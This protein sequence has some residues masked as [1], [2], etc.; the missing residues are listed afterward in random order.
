MCGV[1]ND[2]FY[3]VFLILFLKMCISSTGRLGARS[4][5]V[6]VVVVAVVAVVVVVVVALLVLSIIY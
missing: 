3:D 4:L 1:E 2:L 6:V 5:V